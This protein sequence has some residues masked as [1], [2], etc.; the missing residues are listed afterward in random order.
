MCTLYQ[1]QNRKMIWKASHMQQMSW[2][3][4]TPAVKLQSAN[5]TIK[6]TLQFSI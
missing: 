6:Q 3:I 2:N 5:V 4:Q 1:N